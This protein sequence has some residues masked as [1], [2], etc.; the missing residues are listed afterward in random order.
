V[1]NGQQIGIV[2]IPQL[3]SKDPASDAPPMNA[4]HAIERA[5]LMLPGEPAPEGSRDPRWQALVCV[6]AHVDDDPELVWDFIEVWGGHDQIDLRD[7]IANC[8]LEP[9]LELH[10]DDFFPLV[11]E[12]SI[13]DASFADMF[14][15]CEP[16]GVAA[17]S[18]NARRF[19]SLQKQL[20]EKFF[21]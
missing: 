21:D 15:R 18:K 17:E 1:Q 3:R 19:T 9:L 20:A 4:A 16:F 8:L 12:R 14:L 2:L 10:F 5:A 13:A 6:G 11:T 7:A